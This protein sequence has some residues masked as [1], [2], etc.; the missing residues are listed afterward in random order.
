[1]NKINIRNWN[2]ST[3]IFLAKQKTAAV[4][5][6]QVSVF[7]ELRKATFPSSLIIKH[8]SFKLDVNTVLVCL[9]TSISGSVKVNPLFCEYVCE[10]V[11]C[12]NILALYTDF[13]C[14]SCPTLPHSSSLR[15]PTVPAPLQSCNLGSYNPPPY[16][17]PCHTE[18]QQSGRLCSVPA[19]C[20]THLN[21]SSMVKPP[22]FWGPCTRLIPWLTKSC[23]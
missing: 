12:E 9:S 14:L 1:M 10:Y 17:I 5:L 15:L 2:S 23:C 11:I 4:Q 19:W 3:S 13:I 6:I 18:P 20:Q 7:S 8:F 22:L 16:C 21:W